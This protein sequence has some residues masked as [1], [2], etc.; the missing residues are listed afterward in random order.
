MWQLWELAGGIGNPDGFRAMAD[1]A[2]RYAM[3][4]IIRQAR[5]RDF[6]AVDHLEQALR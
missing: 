3:V 2:T 5:D 4:D 6:E 1:P